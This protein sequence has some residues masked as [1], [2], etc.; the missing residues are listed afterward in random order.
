M[1]ASFKSQHSQSSALRDCLITVY[2]LQGMAFKWYHGKTGVVWNVTKRAVGV[3]VNK[4]VR[5]LLIICLF[6]YKYVFL[7]HLWLYCVLCVLVS[8]GHLHSASCGPS[9]CIWWRGLQQQKQQQNGISSKQRGCATRTT[10]CSGKR[11]TS[12]C[13][14]ERVL[15]ISNMTWQLLGAASSVQG[16]GG[17]QDMQLPLSWENMD[18][19]SAAAA[20]AVLAQ[21][22]LP[23]SVQQQQHHHHHH[24]HHH[25]HH[26]HQQRHEQQQLQAMD[27][28]R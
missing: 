28:L 15:H 25:N 8:H 7:S 5:D 13:V 14:L 12:G 4:T 22:L 6:A 26:Y 9:G 11:Q 10:T 18:G 16:A 21:L 2:V 17:R 20:L 3:E 1:L 23:S 19:V 27:V 24:H